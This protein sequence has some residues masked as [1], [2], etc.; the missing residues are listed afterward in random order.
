MTNSKGVADYSFFH[1]V[2]QLLVQNIAVLLLLLIKSKLSLISTY[3]VG[4]PAEVSWDDD[5]CSLIEYVEKKK[6][7]VEY[8][9]VSD[10]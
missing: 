9:D 6:R 7:E 1:L 3:M 8:F 5:E 4:A 2:G 10:Q